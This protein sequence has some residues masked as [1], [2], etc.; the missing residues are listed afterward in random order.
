LPAILASKLYIPRIIADMT[1]SPQENPER[2]LPL[3]ANDTFAR[4]MM[5]L[6]TG[7]T[8][9]AEQLFK[10]TL[11]QHPRHVPALNLYSILLTQTGRFEEAEQ[12]VKRAIQE[13]ATSDASFYNYGV[14]LKALK[15]S[16]EAVEQFNRALAINGSV[17]ETLNVR[18]EVYLNL[19]R[20]DD[21][22]A[23]F[24]KALAINPKF[25]GA[26]INRAR[27]LAEL[28]Q[29]D[30]GLGIVEQVLTLQPGNA[31]AWFVRG[32]IF[33]SMERHDEALDAFSRALAIQPG[34]AE[35]RLGLGRAYIW[36][37][38]HEDALATFE[39]LI[40]IKADD[41]DVWHGYG[42][43]L[44]ELGQDDE[45]MAAYQ[46]AVTLKPDHAFVHGSIAGLLMALG[47]IDE[48]SQTY[49]KA[50][51]L[52]PQTSAFY[53]GGLV[54]TKKINAGDVA[55]MEA[56]AADDSFSRSKRKR[57][58]IEFALGN[59]YADSRDH[60]RA[61][62]YLLAA[63]AAKRS[64]IDYRETEIF[65]NFDMIEKV[66]TTELISTRS[67]LGVASRQPIFIIGM[68]R[69]GS[70]LIEQILASH[71]AVDGAGEV[72]AFTEA[73]VETTG[74]VQ[75]PQ[76]SKTPYPDFVPLLDGPMI[77][78]I[79]ENY[80]ARLAALAPSGKDRITDKLLGNFLQAGLIHLVF[81][82][83][84]ILHT[85]RNPVDTCVSCFSIMFRDKV[86]YTYDLAEL[87]RYYVRYQRLMAHWHR[88]LPPGRIL[89]VTYE[90][91]V[92]DLEGQ[93]RRILSHCGLPWDDRCLAF[94]KTERQVR[95]ASV[96]QVRQPIYKSSVS[97]WRAYEEFLGPLLKELGVDASTAS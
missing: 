67:S 50:I 75:N 10:K 94:H 93:A 88:I 27:A 96:T 64:M 25:V 95:T 87:G 43:A 6:Q 32:Q 76:V 61:F 92:A 40:V 16:E 84:V 71:P 78:S 38:R 80:L 62:Q 55:A 13:N 7:K 47:R 26:L 52:D 44:V 2:V 90:D 31:L 1:S 68:P 77:K 74:R 83:A 91:V 23:D 4:A 79:G 72:P 82:N 15:R 69:S 59:A 85:V 20:V 28:E 45:A 53:Y 49:R 24:D 18:G 35:A 81:P 41:P 33:T 73:T 86:N 11:R 48:A 36:L 34:L 8:A 46:K 66:F 39:N 57:M 29:F 9:D 60:R 19:K 51:T 54:S 21:A 56:Q 12:Y 22:L 42:D 97:R 17:P 3:A 5:A 30:A 65:A 58:L 37:K 70:T 14:I 89:D 63:N